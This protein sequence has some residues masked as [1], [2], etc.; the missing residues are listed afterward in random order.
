MQ[1]GQFDRGL[2]LSQALL[3]VSRD[4]LLVPD[5]GSLLD[6]VLY[7]ELTK[8]LVAAGHFEEALRFLNSVP[9]HGRGNEGFESFGAAI[10]KQGKF[11]ELEKWLARIP[12]DAARTTVRLGALNELTR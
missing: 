2:K 1:S 12:H 5:S 9:E 3:D 7:G 11:A 8:T 10:V 4:E 6:D